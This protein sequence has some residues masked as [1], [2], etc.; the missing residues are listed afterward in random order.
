M[1]A[2]Q[3]DVAVLA[4]R[5]VLTFRGEGGEGPNQYL[6]RIARVDDVIDETTLGRVVRAHA[7]LDVL[8]EELGPTGAGI[9]SGVD[10]PAEDDVGGGI[11][12]HDRDLVRGPGEAEVR[13][14]RLRVHDEVRAPV[15]LAQD[16]LDAGD[17]CL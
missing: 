4:F 9:E 17:S 1:S 12:P 2:L 7:S 3:G 6:P 10:L 5:K 16:Q 15:G 13:A 11:G 14:Q 8:L